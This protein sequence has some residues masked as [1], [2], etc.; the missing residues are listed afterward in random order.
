MTYTAAVLTYIRTEEDGVAGVVELQPGDPVPEGAL[1][2]EVD[3]LSAAGAI[4]ESTKR[5]T[6]VKGIL[7]DVG[8]DPEKAATALELEKAGEN[9]K[10]LVE[11]LEKIANPDADGNAAGAPAEG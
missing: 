8:D 1:E 5:D 9:R 2:A 7:A 6:T 10:T 4:V 3:R 11:Q